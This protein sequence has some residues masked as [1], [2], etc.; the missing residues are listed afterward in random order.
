MLLAQFCVTASERLDIF[1][2]V[3]DKVRHWDLELTWLLLFALLH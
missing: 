1:Y 2:T 3:V